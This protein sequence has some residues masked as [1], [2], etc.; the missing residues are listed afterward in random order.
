MNLKTWESLCSNTS[1]LRSFTTIERK[2]LKML[3]SRKKNWTPFKWCTKNQ[4]SILKSKIKLWRQKDKEYKLQLT[5]PKSLKYRLKLRLPDNL[6]LRLWT[7]MVTLNRLCRSNNKLFSSKIR[8]SKFSLNRFLNLICNSSHN[9]NV[10]KRNLSQ[11]CRQFQRQ[12]KI[13]K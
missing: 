10:L 11:Q 4:V 12:L 2:N 13:S 7:W 5:K 1:L 3:R 9:L 6:C 8:C